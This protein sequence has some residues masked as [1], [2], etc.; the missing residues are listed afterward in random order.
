MT[1]ECDFDYDLCGWI[2]VGGDDFDWIQWSGTTSS[3]NTGPSGD[4]TT[5]SGILVNRYLIEFCFE[6]IHLLIFHT[7]MMSSTNEHKQ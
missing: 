1:G 4:H 3:A 6:Y 5:G 2:N 7:S